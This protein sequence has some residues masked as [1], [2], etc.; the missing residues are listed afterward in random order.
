MGA[1]ECVY[2][3][4]Q[5]NDLLK[6]AVRGESART[7]LLGQICIIEGFLK[8]GALQVRLLK[9]GATWDSHT[10]MCESEQVVVPICDQLWPYIA[11]ISS[12]QER[13]KFARD[14][15]LCEKLRM[16]ELGATVGFMD[17]TDVKLGTVRFKGNIRG[18]GYGFGLELNVSSWQWCE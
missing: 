12:P 2:G 5:R 11:A 8:D 4:F 13:V 3:I 15:V 10:F 14:K 18:L 6:D 7:V 17:A 9:D 1:R 16:V